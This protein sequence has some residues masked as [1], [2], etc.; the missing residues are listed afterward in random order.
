MPASPGNFAVA[1]AT[2][3]DG[4]GQHAVH[5]HAIGDA[6]IR[7]RLGHRDDG[8]IDG[9]DGR[10]RRRQVGIQHQGL[11]TRRLEPLRCLSEPGAITRDEDDRR[12]IACQADGR[13]L[14]D[15]LTGA[16]HDRNCLLHCRTPCLPVI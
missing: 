9:A 13:G 12:E 7:E 4:T 2:G 10:I 15:A 16:R 5:L 8:G 6:A 14:A 11:C 3:H 1:A